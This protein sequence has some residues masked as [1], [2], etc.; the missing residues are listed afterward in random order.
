MHKR[1]G[2]GSGIITTNSSHHSITI[3]IFM[4]VQHAI[5][6]NPGQC[7]WYHMQIGLMNPRVRRLWCIITGRM[8]EIES[9]VRAWVF[10]LW[11]L[12]IGRSVGN[13]KALTADI[14]NGHVWNVKIF[15]LKVYES[16]DRMEGNHILTGYMTQIDRE[17]E[18][19]QTC[20][21]CAIDK[22]K[23]ERRH[24]YWVW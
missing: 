9:S 21:C 22:S 12:L 1:Q 6:A 7:L 4:H 3:V 18:K 15:L 8:V 2:E 17:A 11:F 13:N 24:M 19:K 16:H 5:M 10:N 23:T 20:H 14:N